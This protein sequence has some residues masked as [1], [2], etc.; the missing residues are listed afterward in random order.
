MTAA[1]RGSTVRPVEAVA[2]VT[3]LGLALIRGLGPFYEPDLWWHLRAG[4]QILRGGGLRVTDSA[5]VFAERPW[6]ATQWLPEVVAA[7]AYRHWGTGGVLWLRTLCILAI[8]LTVFL[9]AR[10]VADRLPALL[11]AGLT[12]LGAAASL[13]P[14]PQLVSFVLF[15]LTL[16]AWWRTTQDR[17]PRWWLVPLFWLWGC[18]HA[19]WT[20]GIALGLLITTGMFVDRR[21]RPTR[22]EVSRLLLLH[23]M[24]ILALALTPV[25]PRLLSAPLQFTTN[26]ALVADEWKATPVTNPFAA[27]ALAAVLLTAVLWTRLPEPPAVWQVLT[28]VFATACILWMWR[29]VPLGAITVGPLLAQALQQSL[30]PL[31]LRNGGSDRRLSALALAGAATAALVFSLSAPAMQSARYPEPMPAVDKVLSSAPRGSVVFSDLGVSGWLLWRHPS[32]SPVADLRVEIYNTEYLRSYVAALEAKPAWSN[33]V[34]STRAQYALVE[35]DSGI[36]GA[37]ASRLGWVTLARSASY[38]LLAPPRAGAHG[39]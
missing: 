22:R 36:A 15:A 7:L 18:S 24:C 20:F 1:P 3:V 26:A 23:L 17:R 6:L 30:P 28:L 37:L 38:V 10:L 19:L 12:I 14:R 29:L 34:E 33:F 35:E 5:A 16:Y 27:A 9:T 21:S 39:A 31:A 8:A 32:L 25:G 4:D 11:A 13:N 2:L